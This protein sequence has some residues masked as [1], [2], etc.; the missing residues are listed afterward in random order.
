MPLIQTHGLTKRYRHVTALDDCS[1]CVA[2]GEVFGLLGANG[3]GKTTLIRLLLGFLRPTTGTARIDAFDC[4]RQ[5]VD[6]RRRV[7][8]LPGDARLF[9]RMRGDEALDFLTRV[10]PRSDIRRAHALADRLDLDLSRRVSAMSTG[11]RHKLALAATLAADTP[12][13]ILDEPTSN[14]DPTVRAEVAQLV[15]EAKA[16]GRT[17]MFSSHVLS[18]VEEV[19]DRVA[20]LRQ[21]RLVYEQEMEPLRR[22]HRIRALLDGPFPALPDALAEQLTVE[23]RSDREVVIDTPGE[24]SG[25]L[26]WLAT[27]PIRDLVVEP[28]G[29]R[30]DYERFHRAPAAQARPE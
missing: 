21:G 6:V 22:R 15:R 26:G 16:D 2:R 23:H 29:L 1:L 28:A 4:V 5:S 12:L 7:S 27:L 11:M 14:L 30:A 24:L 18:E 3:A 19:C 13:V 8:Y 10:R 25:L 20:I 17:V 9:P